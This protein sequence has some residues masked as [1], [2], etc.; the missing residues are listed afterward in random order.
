MADGHILR[1]KF[2]PVPVGDKGTISIDVL[3]GSNAVTQTLSETGTG[4]YFYPSVDDFDQDGRHDVLI[5]RNGGAVNFEQALWRQDANGKFVRL[6][7]ING[8]NVSKTADGYLAVP[9]RGSAAEWSVD[10][11]QIADAPLTPLATIAV[12]ADKTEGDKVVHSSC[13][14]TVS[15][16]IKALNLTAKAAEKKFCAEPAAKVFDK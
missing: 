15:P 1:V 12:A 4:D 11:Y 16:G 9:A 7:A 13:T 8:V 2:G 10:F 14:L 5:V 3:S 6:G